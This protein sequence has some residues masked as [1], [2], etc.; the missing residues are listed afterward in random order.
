MPLQHDTGFEKLRNCEFGPVTTYKNAREHV[1]HGTSQEYAKVV[2]A[3]SR[4]DGTD[5][6]KPASERF[7]SL[8]DADALL[9]GVAT[10]SDEVV[11]E[12][13][14]TVTADT[15]P[16]LINIQL[17]EYFLRTHSVLAV[18]DPI[19]NPQNDLFRRRALSVAETVA[20][21]PLSPLA[22]MCPPSVPRCKPCKPLSVKRISSLASLPENAFVFGTVPHPLTSLSYIHRKSKLDSAFVRNTPRD[23][24]LVSVTNDLVDKRMGGFQRMQYLEDII[25]QSQVKKH[26]RIS[27][28]D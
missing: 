28:C 2:D 10:Y 6:T 16:S 11:S 3:L 27:S 15:L 17:H 18:L 22:G 1:I 23:D 20:K 14:P 24:W 12:L 26:S 5:E 21:C 8:F 4:L 25:S 13:F 7:S 9:D 19:E